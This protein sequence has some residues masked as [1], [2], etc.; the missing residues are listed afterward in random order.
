VQGFLLA[1]PLPA[2]QFEQFVRRQ[3]AGEVPAATPVLTVT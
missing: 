1:R 2:D 3:Y